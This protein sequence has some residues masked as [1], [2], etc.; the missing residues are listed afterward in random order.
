MSTEASTGEAQAS[1]G[2]SA[3]TGEAFSWSDGWR[4]QMAAG[5]TDIEKDMTQ[6][7]RYESPEQIWR[8]AREFENRFASGDLRSALKTDASD[9]EK[10]QWRREN[11]VPATPTD[12][13]I[14][15][16]EGR[17]QPKEDDAFLKSML[18]SMHAANANQAQID[19]MLNSFYSQVDKQIEQGADKEKQSLAASEDVLRKDWGEDYRVN[20]SIAEANLSRAPEGFR[21][22]FLNGHLEDGT[23]IK[24]DP[25][26]WKWLVQNERQINPMASIV[27]GAQG[28]GA[29]AA[30]EE[31]IELRTLMAN[32]K[33]KYWKG[34][35]AAG[36][37]ERYRQLTEGERQLK[38]K[39][40]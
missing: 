33:S 39:A 31:L 8:K 36:L 34:E 37:Q 6:L 18:E 28:D 19:S 14:N 7:E 20:K 17:D 2:E 35:E 15:M 3:S 21:E 4:N 38:A 1:T 40:G 5:S 13:A 10:A 11:A 30:K 27:P 9:E 32:D 25:D 12:Y 26:A 29:K 22:R 24:A 23:P 16:P